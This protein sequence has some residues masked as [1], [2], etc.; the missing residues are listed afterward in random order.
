MFTGLP[1]GLPSLHNLHPFD[2][3]LSCILLVR[4][5]LNLALHVVSC[6]LHH[7]YLFYPFSSLGSTVLPSTDSLL[8]SVRIRV[9]VAGF[10]THRG[11][12]GGKGCRG[13]KGPAFSESSLLNSSCL[14]V[15]GSLGN[16]RGSVGIWTLIL[17]VPTSQPSLLY[18]LV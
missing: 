17:Y 11:W 8:S 18:Q 5:F 9:G 10:I 14:R 6:L 7:L 16:L 3:L 12:L 2:A 15:W 4:S 1:S 13:C